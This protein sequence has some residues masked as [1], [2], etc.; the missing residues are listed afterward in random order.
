MRSGEK[1]ILKDVTTDVVKY[2]KLVE[3]L[4]HGLNLDIS[5]LYEHVKNNI[6]SESELN[7]QIESEKELTL[8]EEMKLYKTLYNNLEQIKEKRKRAYDDLKQKESELCR[9]MNESGLASLNGKYIIFLF[10]PYIRS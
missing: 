1:S 10:N 2:K 8:I 6:L 7:G 3:R 9:M 4:E 5:K